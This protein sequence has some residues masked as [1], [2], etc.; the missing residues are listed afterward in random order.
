MSCR[1]GEFSVLEADPLLAAPSAPQA[2]AH[3]CLPEAVSEPAQEAEPAQTPSPPAFGT[4][5]EAQRYT[6][7]EVEDIRQRLELLLAAADGC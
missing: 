7:A 2:A 1:N 5:S 3:E 4:H 6:E